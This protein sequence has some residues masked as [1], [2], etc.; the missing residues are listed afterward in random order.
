MSTRDYEFL[1]K[2]GAGSYGTAYR[3][4]SK[5]TGQYFVM[6]KIQLSS[7]D[8]GDLAEKMREVEILSGLIHP[9]INRYKQFILENDQLCI[10]SDYCDKGDLEQYI[11]NQKGMRPTQSRIKKLV[12]EMLLAVDYLHTNGIIHRDLKP[13]NIFLKGPEYQAQIG[14]FGIACISGGNGV[15]VED[16]GTLYYQSPEMLQGLFSEGYDART[17]I[18]SL[19]C[20]LYQLCMG[21][22]PFDANLEQRLIQKVRY[23]RHNQ[24]DES[25]GVDIRQLYEMCMNKECKTRPTARELLALDFVQRWARECGIQTQ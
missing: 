16:V 12:L 21:G 18:W 24:I 3:V 22:V 25:F 1:Q 9:N 11:N 6:K 5:R 14:D 19:G 13:S 17:D 4:R 8:P 15:I 20:I 2:L 7:E 23:Q 10:L